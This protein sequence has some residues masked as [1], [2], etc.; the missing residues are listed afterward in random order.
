MLIL[1]YVKRHLSKLEMSKVAYRFLIGANIWIV[2]ASTGDM[3]C[4]KM[5]NGKARSLK[6]CSK[7]QSVKQPC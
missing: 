7:S 1:K 6:K 4:K 2:G 3:K 5:A